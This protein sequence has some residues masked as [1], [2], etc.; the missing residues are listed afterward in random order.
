MAVRSD[1]LFIEL[2]PYGKLP[3]PVLRQRKYAGSTLPLRA[4]TQNFGHS[5]IPAST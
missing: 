4:T 2:S 1:I 3:L 5:T